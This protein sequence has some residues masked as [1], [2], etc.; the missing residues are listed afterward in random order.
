MGY[1]WKQIK[2][3]IKTSNSYTLLLYANLVVFVLLKIINVLDFLFLIENDYNL[4][5]NYLAIS[6]NIYSTIKKPWTIISYMF[7]HQDFFHLLFNLIWLHLGSKLFLQCFKGRQLISTYI[8]GGV[9]GAI[10]YILAFNIFPV[11][12]SEP[13]LGS[14]TIGSSASILAIFIAISTYRPKYKINLMFLGNISIINIAIFLIIL[15]CILI[16]V[17]NAGGHIAHLG[18]ALFG[19]FYI[20]QIKQGKD[21]SIN[22]TK[23][24]ERIL[25]TFRNKKRISS[26]YKRSKSDHEFNSEKAERSKEIDKIL[27]KIATSGYE[28][29][30]KEEKAM[31]F[32]ASKK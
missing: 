16:P 3:K 21:I 20:Q 29:L 19:Y 11:F 17:S 24:I 32:S 1:I 22:F 28:S 2:I 23:M 13:Y 14:I 7:I 30:D 9:S 25:N 12:Q 26:V 31:L 4:I 15:D 8:L 6:S 18:G 5:N 27:E 10:T